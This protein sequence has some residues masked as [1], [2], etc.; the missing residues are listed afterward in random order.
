[1]TKEYLRWPFADIVE[2]LK[3]IKLWGRKGLYVGSE[4]S[5]GRPFGDGYE[6][7]R[8]EENIDRPRAYQ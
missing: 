5:D 6:F 2:A 3:G 8:L 4:R 1:M 7:P